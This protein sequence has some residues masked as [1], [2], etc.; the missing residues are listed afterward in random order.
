MAYPNISNCLHK[1]K[2]NKQSEMKGKNVL[3]II[4]MLSIDTPLV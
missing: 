4:K 2:T 3:S 1:I